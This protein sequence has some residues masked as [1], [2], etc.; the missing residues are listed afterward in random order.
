[1]LCACKGKGQLLA[2]RHKEVKG[3]QVSERRR[4]KKKKGEKERWLTAKVNDII[5]T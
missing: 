4:K 1:M 3:K 2:P 5:G